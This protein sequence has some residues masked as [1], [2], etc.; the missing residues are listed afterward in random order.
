MRA[1]LFDKNPAA[2]WSLG[3]HQD[4]TVAVRQRRDVAGFGPWTVKSGLLHVAPPVSVLEAMV[5]LRIH[6]D[7]VPPTNAPLLIALGTHRIG[8][9]A[10]AAT[11]PT[12]A[13]AE[14]VACLAERGDIW[15]YRTLVLHASAASDAPRRRLVLQI[16]YA[17]DALPGGME[18]L[19]I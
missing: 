15:L 6:L 7:P 8:L 1:I 10:E 13:A 4:R 11:D 9:V 17:A 12:A 2:N 5:T 19:G 14:V 3:W 16:D 18:F